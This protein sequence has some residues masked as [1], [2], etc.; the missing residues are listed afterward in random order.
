MYQVLL[1]DDEPTITASMQKAINWSSY[2]CE[3]AGVAESGAEALEIV[4]NR[5]VDIV[6][7]DIRMQ[8]MSGLELCQ[9]LYTQY[10]HIQ[11]II[12]SGY[13][14]FSYVQKAVKYGI[15]GYCLKPLEYEELGMYLSRAVSRLQSRESLYDQD[16]LLDALSDEDIP[17]LAEYLKASG[18]YHDSW[19]CAVFTGACPPAVPENDSTLFSMGKRQYGWFS[20]TPLSESHIDHFLSQPKNN[21]IGLSD[22]PCSLKELP[23]RIKDCQIQALQFFIQPS[24]SVCISL[25]D[26]Q[27]QAFLNRISSWL[28]MNNR[29]QLLH[30]LR[31]LKKSPLQDAFSVQTAMRLNNMICSSNHYSSQGDDRYI[32]SVYQL[33]ERYQDF[34]EMLDE[35]CRLILEPD[36][37]AGEQTQMTNTNFIQMMEYLNQNYTQDI[38]TNDLAAHMHMDP[39]YLSRIFKR[40]T[41]TTITRY[42]TELRIHKSC[43]MLTSGNYSISETAS[44]TGFND[45]F[46]FLK[47]FKKVTGMT[48]RQY[49]L[50][51]QL[52]ISHD[53]DFAEQ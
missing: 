14:E 43:Q 34:S 1:V 27:G 33:L 50:G 36:T 44:A 13:A 17:L 16:V 21:C 2:Q 15:L 12:I 37:A 6:I 30:A 23:G 5:P 53:T 9:I 4:R 28:N 46:Y 26:A 31:T 18:N 22:A 49:Q 3:V 25:P 52:D 40:E 19:Y 11:I 8:Q 10:S 35:L 51:E 41:G 42:L 38:S 7:T 20:S 39:G 45:Y 32:Y 47:T 48:P 24:C 29:S